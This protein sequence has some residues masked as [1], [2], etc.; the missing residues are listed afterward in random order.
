[1]LYPFRIALATLLL[2][3][4]ASAAEFGPRRVLLAGG[5]PSWVL[6]ANGIAAS[7]YCNSLT[8]QYWWANQV[9]TSCPET[10]SRASSETYTDASGKLS[11]A[12]NNV[13]AN[14][15]AG[16][17]GWEGRTNLQTQSQFA[18][19]WTPTLVTLTPNAVLAPDGTA[20][21]ATLTDNSTSGFHRLFNT[22]TSSMSTT[23]TASIYVQAGTTSFGTLSLQ[24]NAQV[25]GASCAFNI[26][27]LST[28][29][30]TFG[31]GWTAG[32]CVAVALANGWIRVTYT[33][34]TGGNA[35]LHFFIAMCNANIN[36]CGSYTGT[37]TTINI[38]GVGVE[39]ASTA[40]PY[41]PT[42]TTAVARAA[43]NVIAAAGSQ[44][45]SILTAANGALFVQTNGIKQNTG[46]PRIFGS[47][48]DGT[49][50][51]AYNVASGKAETNNGTTV[52]QTATT[53]TLTGR[54]KVALMW[55]PSGRS[56]Q[57]NNGTIATDLNV[58]G[59][60]SQGQIGSQAASSQFMNGNI[61]I[62]AAWPQPVLAPTQ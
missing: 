47:T 22:F 11:Y 18:T 34:V 10:V 2:L 31:S 14:G 15:N 6:R 49:Y 37:G 52:L 33:F 46:D 26:G 50:L 42:T 20:T 32:T 12:G 56:L 4:G 44:L 8:G 13:L 53:G 21:A 57:M 19:G 1:M 58:A 28:L 60:S 30:S 43:D 9:Q 17:Q 35:G 61:E 59:N 3:S 39:Q 41:I 25:D 48:S 62:L 5:A 36:S 40:S 38:W 54:N 27:T 45:A 29:T 16:Q 55:S 23:Y 7:V 24:D 51:V